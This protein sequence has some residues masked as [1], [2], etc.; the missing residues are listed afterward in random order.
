MQTIAPLWLWATFIVVVLVAL[1]IDFV[2]LKKQVAHEVAVKEALHRSIIWLLASKFHLLTYGL[3]VVLV[4]IG[5]KVV[6][7]DG[8]KIP[9][10]VSLGVVVTV[11]TV[12]LL[13]S[14]R[15]SPQSPSP[16]ASKPSKP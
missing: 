3:A 10:R 2:V 1:F 15:T 6:L 8:F 11:L 7:M 4:F 12:T 14:V 13:C 16:E 9:V 5:T